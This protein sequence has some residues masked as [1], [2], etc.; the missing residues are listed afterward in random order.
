MKSKKLTVSEFSQALKIGL[1]RALLHVRDHGDE[2]VEEVLSQALLTYTA[3]DK[4]MESTRSY[5]LTR[6]VSLTGNCGGYSEKFVRSIEQKETHDR[7]QCLD[8]AET[9]F[10]RG[11]EENRKVISLITESAFKEKDPSCRFSMITSLIEISGNLG[12][13]TLVR[14]FGENLNIFDDYSCDS[15]LEYAEEELYGVKTWLDENSKEDSVRVFN[16]ACS[17][18]RS[19]SDI[20]VE[21]EP[22]D[23]SKVF[24]D[25]LSAIERREKP[26]RYPH[27]A[28]LT[29]EEIEHLCNL[30]NTTED[31][32]TLREYVLGFRRGVKPLEIEV[33]EK[34]LL[35]TESSDEAMVRAAT[36]MLK[37][38]R[39]PLLRKY[40]MS[41]LDR[42]PI[43]AIE[44]IK[45]S[46]E[47]ADLPE[48][49]TSLERLNEPDDFHT[50][51]MCVRSIIDE[52]SE[53]DNSESELSSGRITTDEA[54]LASLFTESLIWLYERN[55][56]GFCRGS[57]LDQLIEWNAI[58]KDIL[59][60]CQWDS[61][62]ETRMTAREHWTKFSL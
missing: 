32:W 19:S 37:K 40:A 57:I 42:N 61:N 28:S 62:S 5:W 22:V 7:S 33:T 20:S 41:A 56:C 16:E 35:L 25:F 39:S 26:V 6:I 54:T 59:Y 49:L 13:E 4:Q 12:F 17:R 3:H 1:G 52:L 31:Q 36:S 23:E 43:R 60:E 48:V 24:A 2:G 18:F 45:R 47:V 55:P 46:I 51:A 10:D 38:V 27:H 15:L 11:F 58:P 34:M 53:S 44:I 8:V 9:F 21:R 14:F 30:I 50:A 29:A